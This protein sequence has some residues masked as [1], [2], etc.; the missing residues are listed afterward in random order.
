MVYP[1]LVLLTVHRWYKICIEQVHSC[2]TTS[3]NGT[4]KLM[5][6]GEKSKNIEKVK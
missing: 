3:K 6:W 2:K 4:P 1:D 5:I